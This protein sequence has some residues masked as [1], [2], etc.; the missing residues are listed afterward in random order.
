MTIEEV[1]QRYI[2][3]EI[4]KDELR[5]MLFDLY[6]DPSE[7]E[8]YYNKI[9]QAP[10]YYRQA[11]QSQV[12]ID[13]NI[14]GQLERSLS[15]AQR[16]LNPGII[17]EHELR[18]EMYM[19]T[20]KV[21]QNSEI[22]AWLEGQG[23]H[24]ERLKVTGDPRT[25]DEKDQAL[26]SATAA[27]GTP[28]R[29]DINKMAAW[30]RGEASQT[31]QG[32]LGTFGRDMAASPYFQSVS[33]AARSA[34]QDWFDP[35]SSQYLMTAAPTTLGGYGGWGR[36]EDTGLPKGSTFQEYVG[37]APGVPQWSSARGWI[38]E[39]TN[40][41]FSPWTSGQ[42]K[43]R[44]GGMNLGDLGWT[45]QGGL[46]YSDSSGLTPAEQSANLGFLNAMSMQ[47]AQ[48][49]ARS[50][51]EAGLNPIAARSMRPVLNTAFARFERENPA[52]GAGEFIRRFATPYA[53]DPSSA[54][55]GWYTS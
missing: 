2:N 16:T 7:A 34:A 37:G 14:V 30:L 25:P 8:D 44:F 47:E 51:A 35:I 24:A 52:V 26:L 13:P 49:M 6:I 42:W 3:G 11:N 50:A 43:S 15:E 54:Y 32:R 10:S 48:Q 29:P 41:T 12:S 1:T 17:R 21:A 19:A 45:D 38:D 39:P 28:G 20:A 4:E 53:T 22:N 31:W 55:G 36:A 18:L 27:D 46:A 23:R 33:P 40:T 9:I 5:Q